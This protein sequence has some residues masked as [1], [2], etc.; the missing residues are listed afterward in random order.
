MTPANAEMAV[1]K[2]KVGTEQVSRIDA[3]YKSCSLPILKTGEGEEVMV[4]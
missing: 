4:K 2:E 3:T 1:G